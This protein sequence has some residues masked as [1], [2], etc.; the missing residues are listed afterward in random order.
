MNDAELRDAVRVVS[1]EVSSPI[2]DTRYTVLK[3]CLQILLALATRY[4]EL[5]EILPQKSC[6]CNDPSCEGYVRNKA[7][8][9]CRLAMMKRLEGVEEVADC[10]KEAIDLVDDGDYKPDSFTTQPW[11]RALDNHILNTKGE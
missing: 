7:I 1:N 11:K 9:D 8:E 3:Q 5:G 6:D 2:F 10:L 4:L